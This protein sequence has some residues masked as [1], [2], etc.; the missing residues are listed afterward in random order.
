MMSLY[1]ERVFLATGSIDISGDG[2]VPK[3]DALA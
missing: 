1:K 2:L 3:L